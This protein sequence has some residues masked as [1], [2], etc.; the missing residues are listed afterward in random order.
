MDLKTNEPLLGL[1]KF[2]NENGEKG[3]INLLKDENV[4]KENPY[5]AVFQFRNNDEK[6]TKKEELDYSGIVIIDEVQT[7]L[8]FRTFI[9][10]TIFTVIFASIVLM[11]LKP[12]KRFT[13]GAEDDER[14]MPE[15]EPFDIA[16]EPKK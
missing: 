7:Q 4:T 10:I 1:V 2:E 6:L 3:I 15:Q 16:I 9:G 14:K 12:L 13:H 5:H 8:E 11:M